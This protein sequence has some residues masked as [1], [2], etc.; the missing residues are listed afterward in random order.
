MKALILTA[1]ALALGQTLTTDYG[2]ATRL[3]IDA[4][5]SFSVETTRSIERDGQPVE[6][7]WGGGGST[8]SETRHVVQVDEYL[9]KADGRPTRVR[10][11]FA[12]VSFEGEA[13]FGDQSRELERESPFDG[14][15][16]ELAVDED[17]DVEVEVTDGVAP[18]DELLE[19]HHPDLALDAFLPESEVD[20]G[21]SW[22]LDGDQ[23]AR[24]LGFDLAE[25]L[26]PRP[27]RED[28]GG[29]RGGRGGGRGRGGFGRGGGGQSMARYF[30]MGEWEG[31]A[32]LESLDED[33][34]GTTCALIAIEI[35]GQGELPEPEFGGRGRFAAGPA[36]A[37]M[38]EN[39]FEITAE[40]KLYYSLAD[41]RPIHFE[42][43]GKLGLERR[44]ERNSERGSMVISTNEEGTFT[45]TVTI[46]AE[47]SE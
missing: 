4:S 46:T 8:S 9:E 36:S 22:E 31:E 11:T 7:R 1:G 38:G 30:T 41:K 34:E 16:M 5:T 10:R 23:I 20:A 42:L 13:S 12:D 45:Q 35:E 28:D 32:T 27:Q 3:R 6:G 18:D 29:D 25:T 47:E 2:Q 44:M 17:G 39:E 14:I 40:G 26:F 33:Y 15:V 24:A 21:D 37:A 43:E 19:G